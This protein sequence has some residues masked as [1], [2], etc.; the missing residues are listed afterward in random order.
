[1]KKLLLVLGCYGFVVA[2]A[3]AGDRWSAETCGRLVEMR[4]QLRSI[5]GGDPRLSATMQLPIVSR[6][7]SN[8]AVGSVKE[9]EVLEAR[10]KAL[11]KSAR[12][13]AILRSEPSVPDEVE[14]PRAS[15]PSPQPRQPMFCDTTPKAYGGSYTD[16]F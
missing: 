3:A 16:C 11:V 2:P 13:A 9:Y 14:E 10:S 15:V 8:C 7:Y 4:D 6:L 12:A 1:M 5:K